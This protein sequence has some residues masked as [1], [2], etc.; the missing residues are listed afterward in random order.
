MK[1]LASLEALVEHKEKTLLNV[2]FAGND[3]ILRIKSGGYTRPATKHS[4][5][6]APPQSVFRRYRLGGSR[7]SKQSYSTCGNRRVWCS[8]HP[9]AE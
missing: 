5:G 9:Q 1:V 6:F 8:L 2:N 7:S 3:M 4:T